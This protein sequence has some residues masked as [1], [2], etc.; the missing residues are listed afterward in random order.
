MLTGICQRLPDPA[1]VEALMEALAGTGNASVST[2]ELL[3]SG[4]VKALR[5]Y[6]QG[7]GGLSSSSTPGPGSAAARQAAVGPRGV[8][9]V[10]AASNLLPLGEAPLMPIWSHE[11]VNLLV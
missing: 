1:A 11:S 9:L 5:K 4:T 2:F 7:G 3:S 10:Q 8:A 6:L